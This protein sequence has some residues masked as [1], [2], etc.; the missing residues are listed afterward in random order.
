LSRVI[1]NAVLRPGVP[2]L[3]Q[4]LPR[5]YLPAQA[6]SGRGSG[7]RLDGEEENGNCSP[8]DRVEAE[9]ILEKA[10]Q[11]ARLIIES[12]RE[13]ADRLRKEARGQGY[14]EGVKQG[15]QDGQ[16][17]A[18]DLVEQAQRIYDAVR[19]REKETLG[20][21][22]EDLIRL[23]VALVRKIVR[24]ELENDAEMVVR[25][26]LEAVGR[27]EPGGKLTV[28]V[29][30]VEVAILEG[31]QDEILAA[32]PGTRELE[33]IADPGI[34]PGECVVEGDH[35]EIDGRLDRQLERLEEFL[36]MGDGDERPS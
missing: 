30:P 27:L 31:F 24:R 26:A 5:D 25:L 9:T 3:L 21:L 16:E 29:N 2:R 18:R 35:E 11:E 36:R 22:K 8:D 6:A 28:R 4:I 7:S 23:V 32:A 1:K 17:K 19:R 14:E 33:I 13:E 15:Y 12:A 34:E 20:S 10:R